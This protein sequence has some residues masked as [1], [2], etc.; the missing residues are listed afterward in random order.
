MKWR[1][2]DCSNIH[3]SEKVKWRKWFA[4]HP[5]IIFTDRTGYSTCKHWWAWLEWV[6]RRGSYFRCY[7]GWVYEYR[8][9]EGG[10]GV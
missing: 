3:T 4:W 2:W 1:T 5:V 8:S 7:W 6:E 10:N 9:K